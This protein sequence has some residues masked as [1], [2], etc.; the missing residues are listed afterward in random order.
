MRQAASFAE[1][2]VE[3]AGFT[4]DEVERLK[5]VP[6][7]EVLVSRIEAA[8]SRGARD[9]VGAVAPMAAGGNTRATTRRMLSHLGYTAQEL[10]IVHRLMAGS[11]GGW[12][13]LL[14]LY[15]GG[16]PLCQSHRDYVARQLRALSPARK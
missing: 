11:A 2:A 9:P 4:V 15:A 8:Q 6:A 16:S 1:W 3:E 13:G 12:P 10:R 5:V 14:R 7:L